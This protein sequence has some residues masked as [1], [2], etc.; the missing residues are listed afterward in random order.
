M[1]F[2]LFGLAAAISM[3]S[4]RATPIF[5][6]SD[7][8][9]IREEEIEPEL[10]VVAPFGGA[11]HAELGAE[12]IGE[13]DFDKV[14]QSKQGRE[15]LMAFAKAEFAS[16]NLEFLIALSTWNKMAGT[17]K[18]IFEKYIEGGSAS[19]GGG[20]FDVASSE[21]AKVNLPAGME[22][23]IQ[24]VLAKFENSKERRKN[25]FDNSRKFPIDI[26][27]A[28]KKEIIALVKRDTFDRFKKSEEGA[29]FAEKN[30]GLVT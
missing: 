5:D 16:E 28:A 22:S 21:Q 1:K 25:D 18:N 12:V 13:L 20:G 7:R 19:H 8:L 15:V 26:F 10:E 6:G 27:D 23:K 29:K 9:D 30:P 3:V 11:S 24:N 4:Q 14:F 17:A 2:A